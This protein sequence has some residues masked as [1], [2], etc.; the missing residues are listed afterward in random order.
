M[1]CRKAFGVIVALL[2]VGP[3]RITQAELEFGAVVPVPN[4][5]FPGPDWSTAILPDQDG[6]SEVL[7]FISVRGGGQGDSDIWA[8]SLDSTTGTWATPQNIGSPVNS[9]STE[10]NPTIVDD[11]QTRS[12]FFSDYLDAAPPKLRPGGKGGGDLWMSTWNSSTDTWNEAENLS[13]LNTEFNDAWQT[14]SADGQT[15]IFAS[16]RP[17]GIGE[18]DLWTSTWNDETG[19]WGTATN[20]GD[21]VNGVGFEGAP[22]LS[23]DGS[24]LLFGSRRPG[25]L[26]SN[27]LWMTT[28]DTSTGDWQTPLPLPASIN[29]SAWEGDVAISP[30]G[31]TLYF[32]SDRNVGGAG[33]FGI[34]QAAILTGSLIDAFDCN[35]DGTL[36]VLDA[37]CSDIASLDGTLSAANL[38]QGDADG[39][40]RVQFEDF[41]IL[42][43][44]FGKPGLYTEGD[45]DKDGEVQFRDFLLISAN[46][47]QSV[48]TNAAVPE[49]SA[50]VL[51]LLG[52]IGVLSRH[53][54]V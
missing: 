10:T 24:M 21:K 17:G 37:N 29:S 34:Y 1:I 2:L 33:V 5:N 9:A 25:G 16:D 14:L 6:T 23:P 3:V 43:A 42:A 12:I 18:T 49:P 48:A 53:R 20:L 4:I 13:A 19:S 11:G 51:L 30:D 31:S 27:D 36:D 41:L 39:D 26:G 32:T 54:R 44:N 47:G 8:A 52:V 22:A 7:Y 45:F 46:F 38:I 40:G 15:I 35:G 28:W 50:L